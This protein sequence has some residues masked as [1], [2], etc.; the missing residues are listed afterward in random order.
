MMTDAVSITLRA[1]LKKI[2]QEKEMEMQRLTEESLSQLEA[3][4]RPSEKRIGRPELHPCGHD[5]FQ[6]IYQA[7][8]FMAHPLEFGF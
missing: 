7:I 4:V 1:A 8:F 3:D 5:Q 6:P 2:F